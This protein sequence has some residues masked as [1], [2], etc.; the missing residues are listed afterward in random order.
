[1]HAYCTLVGLEYPYQGEFDHYFLLLEMY[2]TH[3]ILTIKYKIAWFSANI[4][5]AFEPYY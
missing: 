5:I 1:M 4:H 2:E 3:I